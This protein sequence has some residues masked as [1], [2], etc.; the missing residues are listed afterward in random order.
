MIR[1]QRPRE[2]ARFDAECR[3]R[4]A[5]WLAA[6]P[7]AARPR[8]LWRE[9]TPD[10]ARAFRERCGYSAVVIQSGTV[11]HFQSWKRSPELAYE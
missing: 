11:D 9:F 3:R 10:L 2:P 1:V 7:G 6:N 5:R 4:G 8:P